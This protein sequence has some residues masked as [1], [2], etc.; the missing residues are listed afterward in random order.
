MSD[1]GNMLKHSTAEREERHTKQDTEA[2]DLIEYY[3]LNKTR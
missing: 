3:L 2:H 1:I